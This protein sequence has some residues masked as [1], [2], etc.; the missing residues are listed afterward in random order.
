[1][2]TPLA[3]QALIPPLLVEEMRGEPGTNELADAKSDLEVWSALMKR[4][5]ADEHLRTMFAAAFPETRV[6]D[7]N[8]G[9]A[10]H[11]IAAFET[12]QWLALRTPLDAFLAGDGAALSEDAKRGAFLFVGA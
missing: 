4:L 3:V 8:F 11:A 1:V 12:Q 5:L 6:E 9:H 7:L 10:A 2:T